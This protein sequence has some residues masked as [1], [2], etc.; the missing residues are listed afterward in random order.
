MGKGLVITRPGGPEVMKLEELPQ[1]SVQR[2]QVRVAVAAAG[3]NPV[4]AG[5]RSDP[6]WA[7]VAPPYVVG[8]EFAGCV[9]EVGEEVADP[10]V[11]TEVWGLLPVRGSRW[12]AYASELVVDAHLV[13]ER[14][15]A[16]DVLEAAA[17]PLAGG[18]ALQLLDRLDPS[19]GEWILI[20]GAAGGVGH[21]LAQ[22][23]HARG[24]RVAAL[25]SAPRHPLLRRLGVEVMVD[26]HRPDAIGVAHAQVGTD[27]AMVADL[28]G[29]GAVAASL[30]VMAECGRAGSIA[31]LTGDFDEAL[32]RNVQLHGVLLR[33]GQDVLRRLSDLVTAE[34]L[35]PVIDQVL[36][37]VEAA[38]AHS[39]VETGSGQGK[40][41]LTV[42]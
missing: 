26:R 10:A 41:V 17:L 2:H 15:L 28:V 36:P 30:G 5:N 38:R 27:F 12:G 32:D 1:R 14:P 7:G 20:H 8:Y 9:V 33:P 16:L 6:S 40:L 13:A 19:P 37:L 11:G 25:A 29:G 23:C 35:R 42:H 31:G 4:D 21:L 24:L 22:L 3:V 34:R 39:R 18:T